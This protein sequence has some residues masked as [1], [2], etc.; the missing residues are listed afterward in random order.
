[1]ASPECQSGESPVRNLDVL[2]VG[3]GLSGISAAYRLKT[4]CPDSHFQV[5][6][7][8][9][10][11]GGTW[12]LF[13]Y[14]GIRSDSDMYTFGF[15][16]EPWVDDR[17]M[18]RG[19]TINE[20]V[21]HT[22]EKYALNQYILYQH[23]LLNASWSER[24]KCW[25][26]TLS[27][28]TGELHW[29]ARFLWLCTGYYDYDS[30]HYPQIPGLEEFGGR[31]IHPQHWPQ[32]FNYENRTIVVVGSGSTATT[33]VPE[34]AKK[35]SLVTMLQRSPSYIAEV[36]TRDPWAEFLHRFLPRPLA[37]AILRWK[38]ILYQTL[39]FGL[40]RRYPAMFRKILT[41]PWQELF[42]EQYVRQHFT[43]RYN[44]WEQ[45]LCVDADGEFAAALK[46]GTADIVTD[47]IAACDEDGLILQSGRI[48]PTDIIVTATGLKLQLFGKAKLDIDGV[49]LEASEHM[50]YKGMMLQDVPNLGI[51]LGYTNMSWTLKCDLISRYVCRLLNFMSKNGLVSCR[52]KI[53]DA[54]VMEEKLIDF[55]SSYFQ[56]AEHLLPKQGSKAPWK[57]HQ[58]YIHDLIQTKFA[59]LDDG[60]LEFCSRDIVD[61]SGRS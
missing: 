37:S 58:S 28:E 32:D 24:E 5:V 39:T 54:S 12:D 41:K 48:L 14:P 4:E 43:P 23:K 52:P 19:E 46:Q 25:N 57:L 61:Q 36:P 3:A 7:A 51:S 53:R 50:L 42:G 30:G 59:Q 33:L 15:P 16:F 1:M 29:R 34:L 27:N 2:V 20:Y 6:E 55:N 56:R 40:A 60:V 10:A 47:E 44:P 49:P 18:A 45:R 26:L 31:V 35:A 21:H 13:R 11:P 8:R 9:S 17:T 22:L 38:G